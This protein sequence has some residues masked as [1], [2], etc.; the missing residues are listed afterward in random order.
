M[1]ILFTTRQHSP[2]HASEL[3]SNI[4]D[5]IVSWCTLRKPVHP[6]PEAS[7]VV[8]D[9]KQH[10]T[11]TVDEHTSQIDVAAFADA[12]QLL[13]ASGRVLPWHDTNPSCEIAPSAEGCPVTDGGHGC[14]RDQRAEAGDL[15]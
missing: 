2:S 14:S 15:E 5:D 9:P 11:S 10:C 6:L 12:E 8:L 13:F 7:G 3:V 1:S 4:H